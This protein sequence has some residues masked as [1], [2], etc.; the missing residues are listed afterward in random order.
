MALYAHSFNT[1]SGTLSRPTTTTDHR[2][3]AAVSQWAPRDDKH[4]AIWHRDYGIQRQNT[5]RMM[6]G[7]HYM[8]RWTEVSARTKTKIC[9]CVVSKKGFLK[10][11]IPLVVE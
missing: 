10:E 11:V 1:P 7:L 3:I 6:Y 5:Q 9:E 8:A 4:P 2:Q